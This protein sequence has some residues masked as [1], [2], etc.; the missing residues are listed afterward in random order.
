MPSGGNSETKVQGGKCY[1]KG[2]LKITS[3]PRDA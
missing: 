3:E 2:I 1:S